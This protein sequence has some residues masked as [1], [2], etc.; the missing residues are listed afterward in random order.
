MTPQIK[1]V[2]L[3]NLYAHTPLL[4]NGLSDSQKFKQNKYFWKICEVELIWKY[5]FSSVLI[6]V[7]MGNLKNSFSLT[8]QGV[9]WLKALNM[10]NIRSLQCCTPNSKCCPEQWALKL[11]PIIIT[12]TPNSPNRLWTP[13]KAKME[14]KVSKKI[15]LDLISLLH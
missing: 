9:K 5:I 10:C 13:P 11:V 2:S 4:Q 8:T 3:K 6:F 15:M 12:T 7:S 1:N 14:L